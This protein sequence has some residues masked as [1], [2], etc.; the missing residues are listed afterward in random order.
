MRRGPA[1]HSPETRAKMS[2]T[3]KGRKHTPEHKAA[4][5]EGKRRA[6]ANPAKPW[7]TP[8][9]AAYIERMKGRKR[10][11]RSVAEAV[12]AP[13]VG[14]APAEFAAPVPLTAPR[15]HME[16]A[17]P[18]TPAEI[19]PTRAQGSLGFHRW[20]KSQADHDT[21]VGRLLAVLPW[22][23]EGPATAQYRLR[24]AAS[25]HPELQIPDDVAKAAA[26]ATVAQWRDWCDIKDGDQ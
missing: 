15:F 8:A 26:E 6:E 5:A 23:F 10:P 12:D 16:L 13:A 24:L 22:R 18:P 17:P 20:M 3:R 19:A 2:E 14:P 1:R 11:R 4:I 7:M 9:R 25:A 21:V